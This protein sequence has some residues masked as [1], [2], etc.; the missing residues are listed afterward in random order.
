MKPETIAIGERVEVFAG[1]NAF[2][3]TAEVVKAPKGQR[4]TPDAFWVRIPGS[5]Q[6]LWWRDLVCVR[7]VGA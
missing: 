3:F 6:R 7:K 5:V 1:G 2:P 4:S